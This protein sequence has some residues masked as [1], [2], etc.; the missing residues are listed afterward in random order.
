MLLIPELKASLKRS[1]EMVSCIR[2][3]LIPLILTA[4]RRADTTGAGTFFMRLNKAW[5][6][7]L[8]TLNAR[9]ID[10]E[11]SHASKQAIL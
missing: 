10:A 8:P 4:S 2:K 3:G 11:E 1:L 7:A 9:E 6:S 5:D